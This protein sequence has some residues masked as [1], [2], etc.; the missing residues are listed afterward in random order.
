M[1]A[2]K[3]VVDVIKAVSGEID[4]WY[5]A[6][7]ESVPR[8]LSAAHMADAVERLASDVK[9]SAA[10]TV[11]SACEQALAAAADNDRIIVF[12]SFYTVAEAMRFFAL[13]GQ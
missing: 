10:S 11:A 4:C 12:G 6:G 1:L 13:P 5:P 2:D 3:P 9:L 8:G 7:L